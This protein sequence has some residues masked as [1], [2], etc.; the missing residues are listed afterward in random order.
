MKLI[1]LSACFLFVFCHGPRHKHGPRPQENVVS[2][3]GKS[4]DQI[5]KG[6]DSWA[7]RDDWVSGFPVDQQHRALVCLDRLEQAQGK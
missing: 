1:L 7:N 5:T 2:T 3:R 4:C 6:F